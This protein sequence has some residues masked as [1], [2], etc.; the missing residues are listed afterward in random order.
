[1]RPRRTIAASTAGR[2][3]SSRLRF[4]RRARA[5]HRAACGER[6][7]ARPR[8][9]EPGSAMART[10]RWRAS[11]EANRGD[12][13]SAARPARSSS[14]AT[15]A[16]SCAAPSA[17]ARL[18]DDRGHHEPRGETARWRSRGAVP[19][20]AVSSGGAAGAARSSVA[21]VGLGMCF[22]ARSRRG[23]ARLE[24]DGVGAIVGNASENQDLGSCA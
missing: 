23:S 6:A 19:G 16:R 2:S 22:H 24:T 10:T 3:R 9:A 13:A 21:K 5:A 18:D 7:E 8:V 17:A 15:P 11:G 20:S 1:M 12:P 4:A 14:M